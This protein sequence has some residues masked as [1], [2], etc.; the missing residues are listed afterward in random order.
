MGRQ[1]AQSYQKNLMAAENLDAA[2]KEVL[3]Q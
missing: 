3:K 2:V 1:L